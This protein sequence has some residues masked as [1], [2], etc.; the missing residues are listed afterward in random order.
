MNIYDDINFYVIKIIDLL[1][2]IRNEERDCNEGALSDND[3]IT[4]IDYL[5]EIRKYN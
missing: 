5:L 2:N 3:F 4:I 1:N